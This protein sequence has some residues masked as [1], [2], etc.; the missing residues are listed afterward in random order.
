MIVLVD[1]GSN[2]ASKYPKEKDALIKC[3][4]LIFIN[5]AYESEIKK[6]INNLNQDKFWS[7]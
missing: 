1:V 4:K 7:T 6:L 3:C 2:L 5:A